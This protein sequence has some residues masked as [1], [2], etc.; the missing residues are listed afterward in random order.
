[1]SA[2]A[3]AADALAALA[4]SRWMWLLAGVLVAVNAVVFPAALARIGT[5]REARPLDLRP[6]YSA[7]EAYR[8]LAA[9]GAAGRRAYRVVEATVDVVYPVLYTVFLAALLAALL[10]RAWPGAGASAWLSML[11]F[12]VLLADLLENAGIVVLL[13]RFPGSL[14]A[15]AP[16]VS[17]FTTAKWTMLGVVLA[18][19]AASLV[20][21]IGARVRG[22][23]PPAAPGG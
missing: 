5:T 20:A 23:R 3:R 16:V 22:R 2:V 17:A 9:M 10:R 6:S 13:G 4:R 21:A 18:L 14:D 7:D 15:V 1:M 8:T 12:G 11:P 19:I